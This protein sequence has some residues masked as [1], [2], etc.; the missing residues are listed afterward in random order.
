MK[1]IKTLSL[2]LVASTLIPASAHAQSPT[3]MGYAA[4]G[5]G[6]IAEC[7]IFKNYGYNASFASCLFGI[8]LTAYLLKRKRDRGLS[9]SSQ[10]LQLY[11]FPFIK[12]TPNQGALS[13]DE[14]IQEINKENQLQE[15]LQDLGTSAG[16]GTYLAFY[17]A[18]VYT[19]LANLIN[20]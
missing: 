15:T 2:I 19:I 1:S 12:H 8:G 10:I 13:R 18:S 7:Y 4:A 17:G 3:L 11:P 9:I 16:F 6:F 14:Y 5:A 20:R